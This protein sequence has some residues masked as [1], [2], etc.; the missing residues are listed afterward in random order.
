[1]VLC[2]GSWVGFNLPALR[3]GEGGVQLGPV[4]RGGFPSGCAVKAFAEETVHEARHRQATT[5]GFVENRGDEGTRNQRLV[6]GR[7]C[8]QGSMPRDWR[9]LHPSRRPPTYDAILGL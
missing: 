5:F 2:C 1:M 3:V 7:L 8:H 6:T 9:L 4:M